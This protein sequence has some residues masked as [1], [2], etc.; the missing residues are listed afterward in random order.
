MI[1]ED[2]KTETEDLKIK[3]DDDQHCTKTDC[4]CGKAH[5]DRERT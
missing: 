4:N 2:E 1:P 3:V 5:L